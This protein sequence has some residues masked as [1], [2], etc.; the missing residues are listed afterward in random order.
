MSRRLKY[1]SRIKDD[2]DTVIC[3][4]NGVISYDLR[5]QPEAV[6]TLIKMYQND[7]RIMLASNIGWRVNDLFAFLKSNGVPMQIF[8]AM[9]TAGEMSHF[10]FRQNED[11]GKKYYFLGNH[12]PQTTKE[13]DYI[14]VKNIAEA[15][16]ML[17]ETDVEGINLNDYTSLL[18]QALHYHKPLICVGN[19]TMLATTQG[20]HDCVGALAE[21]YAMMGGKL[22]SFGKPDVRIAAYLCENIPN[23]ER[24][25][26][27]IIG[28]CMATDMRMGNTFKAQTLFLTGGVHQMSDPSPQQ[29]D[30]LSAEYGLGVDYY[31][32]TLQW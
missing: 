22:I 26:C 28:D 29:I 7:K 16:F 3:G 24:S 17:A 18:E 6:D 23:F 1:I 8:D 19:D 9:I 20:V 27:L 32:E 10:H 4:F 12:Q 25:R 11:L 14:E 21:Q 2:F 5:I 31:A 13:T 15:D 30:A